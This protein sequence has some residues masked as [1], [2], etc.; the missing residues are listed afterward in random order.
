MAKRKKDNRWITVHIK[1]SSEDAGKVRLMEFMEFLNS[2]KNCLK[3]VESNLTGKERSSLYY[4][5]AD[6]RTGS[7]TV[8]LE[9]VQRE[10][11]PD[12][13]VPV[14]EKFSDG[15]NLI[16]KYGKLPDGFDQEV[17]ETYRKLV[18]PLKKHVTGI[19]IKRPDTVTEITIQLETNIEKI[20]GEDITSA[21]SVMGYL[22]A[23]NVHGVN[24]FYIYPTIGPTK[25]LCAFPDKLLDSV[26]K[27]LKG[28]VSVSGT[29]RYKKRE[30]FPYQIDVEDLEIY[31]PSEKT[32]SLSS[33]R[34]MAPKVTGG[35]DSVA[36]VRKLRDADRA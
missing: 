18:V 25:L 3:K 31:P 33:L 22:D 32:P 19:E 20:L 34:G 24:H 28:Y 30:I 23:V 13:A 2:L 1:G 14:L 6:L 27:G 11:G 35:L 29:L 4:R 5:I 21:G 26:R 10:A 36:F 12:I 9:A 17:L 16:Q 7:A 15:L 8:S